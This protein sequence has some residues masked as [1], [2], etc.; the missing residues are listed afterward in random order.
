MTMSSLTIILL[1]V[2]VLAWSVR[3]YYYWAQQEIVRLRKYKF[4]TDQFFS[5]AEE[6]LSKPGL[7]D[8]FLNVIENVNELIGDRRV[9]F[10][11]LLRH[12][13]K[14]K[15]DA[16]KSRPAT[17]EFEA[18]CKANPDFCDKFLDG[19]EG[20]LEAFSYANGIL[21]PI[22]R[23]FD[24]AKHVE[25]HDTLVE[26]EGEIKEVYAKLHDWAPAT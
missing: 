15:R 13:F 7:P 16:E 8:R 14:P 18:F 17:P 25:H 9:P 4:L 24:R 11:M 6:A 5:V 1:F 20:A 19:A 22:I 23:S 21:G 10:V 26:T 2:L 3:A 12:I